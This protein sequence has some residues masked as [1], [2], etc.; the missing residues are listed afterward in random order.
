MRFIVGAIVL[1]LLYGYVAVTEHIAIQTVMA[2]PRPYTAYAVDGGC[3]YITAQ[4][5]AVIRSVE[6]TQ[7][8]LIE[9]KLCK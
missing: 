2:Q 6:A 7:D 8:E 5:Y 4:G 3:L 1:G 9:Q